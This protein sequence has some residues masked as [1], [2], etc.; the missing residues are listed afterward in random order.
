MSGGGGGGTVAAAAAKAGIRSSST[1]NVTSSEAALPPFKIS[2]TLIYE[3]NEICKR[4]RARDF[5]SRLA[6]RPWA[7][8]TFKLNGQS[9]SYYENNSSTKVK[10]MLDT[11]SCKV[12]A[13]E[14]SN[15]KSDGRDFVLELEVC[16]IRDQIAE[17]MF[18]SFNSEESRQTW[19]AILEASSRS[20]SWKVIG[21][22]EVKDQRE[23]DRFVY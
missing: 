19:K 1:N 14:K 17:S 5:L 13:L 12:V 23:K 10:G 15:E 2:A 18:I 20:S 6:S 21:S 11:S 4:G 22:D 16:A 3:E 7:S 8:R 9:L